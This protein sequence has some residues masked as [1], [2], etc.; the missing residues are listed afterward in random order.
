MPFSWLKWRTMFSIITTAPST[1]MPK[2]NAPRDSKFAGMCLKSK[3]MRA[4]NS[5]N[6]IVAATIRAPRT[7]P[8]NRK[9]M[10]DTRIIPS[11]RLCEH[12]VAGEVNKIAAIDEGNNLH[13]RWQDVIV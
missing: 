1:T 2:S 7:L 10:I 11:V 12:R 6:G 8:R 4:N 9:S 3:Q 13:A 5:E